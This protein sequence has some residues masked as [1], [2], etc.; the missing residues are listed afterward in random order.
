MPL[1]STK[2]ESKKGFGIWLPLVLSLYISVTN[3]SDPLTALPFVAFCL[4]YALLCPLEESIGILLINMVYLGYSHVDLYP[5]VG[6]S[7]YGFMNY[8][9]IAV[10]IRGVLSAQILRGKLAL[11]F[12]K[13]PVVLLIGYMAMQQRSASMQPLVP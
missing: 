13:I 3:L 6:I 8:C 2:Q 4:G 5:S 1:A 12:A 9:Y 10:V 11:N 7:N